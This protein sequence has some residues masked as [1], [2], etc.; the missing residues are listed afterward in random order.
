MT[1]TIIIQYL[2]KGINP[3]FR[4][5]LI[6]R[7][8]S[9]STI[10]EFLKQVKVE[11]DLHNTFTQSQTMSVPLVAVWTYHSSSNRHK[12]PSHNVVRYEQEYRS[13]PNSHNKT[14]NAESSGGNQNSYPTNRQGNAAAYQRSH[15]DTESNV[16]A[17]NWRT[18]NPITM[19]KVCGRQNHR[20]INFMYKRSYGCY[21][22]G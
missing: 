2:M 20:S 4:K 22:C 9:I 8:S 21:N 1:D 11:Q 17:R 3:E 16:P 12:K 10:T 5:E 19:C 14:T 7:Q 13:Q 18:R 15:R 6:R